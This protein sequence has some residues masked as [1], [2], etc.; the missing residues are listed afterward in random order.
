[1][2]ACVFK[3]IYLV[4]LITGIF[5]PIIGI[6]IT[7][8]IHLGNKKDNYKARK[9]FYWGF[10]VEQYL[11]GTFSYRGKKIEF[12]DGRMKIQNLYP[13]WENTGYKDFIRKAQAPK[14]K[15]QSTYENKFAHRLS[16]VLNRVGQAAFV[17]DLPLDHI[18][19]ISSKMILEDWEKSK[20]LIKNIGDYNA[21]MYNRKFWRWIACLSCMYMIAEHACKREEAEKY[22]KKYEDKYL[23]DIISVSGEIT[24]DLDKLQKSDKALLS[25]YTKTY[26]KKLEKKFKKKMKSYK[27]KYRH[28]CL[29]WVRNILELLTKSIFLFFATGKIRIY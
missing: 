26:T 17:G 12:K 10:F 6:I 18:F 4:Y 20:V 16:V 1:M 7:I 21:I 22:I 15:K 13:D 9:L 25:K 11:D 14:G 27:L 29:N 5:L 28:K 3:S 8:L 2:D 23:M 24:K 19:S